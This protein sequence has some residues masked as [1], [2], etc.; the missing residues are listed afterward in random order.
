MRYAE[1]H[2]TYEMY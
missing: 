2:V 1:G